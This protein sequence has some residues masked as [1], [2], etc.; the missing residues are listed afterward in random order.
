MASLAAD[1]FNSAGDVLS[2]GSASWAFVLQLLG[3]CL[4]A[5]QSVSVRKFLYSSPSLS[6]EFFSLFVYFCVFF[7]C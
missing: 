5:D 1:Q 3:L 7:C 6:R 4:A 2:D